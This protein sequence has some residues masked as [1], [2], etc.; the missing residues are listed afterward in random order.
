MNFDFT[1]V[2]FCFFGFFP[3]CVAIF[4]ISL[5]STLVVF[6]FY[7]RN[8]TSFLKILPAAVYIFFKINYFLLR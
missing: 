7:K 8:F 5:G 2:A 3:N 1:G 6:Y 4:R